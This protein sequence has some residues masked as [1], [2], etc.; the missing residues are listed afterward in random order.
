MNPIRWT[1]KHPE[2]VG[3]YWVR[4]ANNRRV[5]RL[6]HVWTYRGKNGQMFTNEDGGAPVDDTETYPDAEWAGPV[7]VQEPEESPRAKAAGF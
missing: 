7:F 6:V 1:R 3:Y 2:K 4:Y 5:K